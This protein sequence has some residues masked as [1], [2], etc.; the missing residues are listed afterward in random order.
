MMRGGAVAAREAHN[1]EVVGSIPTPA[2]KKPVFGKF[3]EPRNKF[4]ANTTYQHPNI[5]TFGNWNLEIVWFLYLGPWN[6]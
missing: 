1:L 2:T 3:Q 5:Q 6:F 4:Q